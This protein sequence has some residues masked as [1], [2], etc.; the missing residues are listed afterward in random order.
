MEKKFRI[1]LAAFMVF[2]LAFS[3]LFSLPMTVYAQDG[4]L[5]DA[6]LEA[7]N[8]NA[9]MKNTKEGEAGINTESTEDTSENG[10]NITTL[11]NYERLNKTEEKDIVTIADN[12]VATVDGKEYSSLKE[13][14]GSITKS[15]TVTLVSDVEMSESITIPANIA[16]TLTSDENNHTISM[17]STQN[18]KSHSVFVVEQGGTLVIDSEK[19]T[20]TRAKSSEDLSGLILCHGTLELKN[21]ILDGND[22]E[23]NSLLNNKNYSAGIVQVCGESATFTMNGGEIKNAKTLYNAGGVRVCCDAI[24]YLKGGTI[25]NI[26][27]GGQLNTGPVLVYADNGYYDATGNATFEMDGGIIENN[28]GYRGAGVFVTSTEYTYTATMTMRNGIIQNNTCT[29]LGKDA[30]GAGAGIYIQAKAEVSMS[31][32]SIIHNTVNG[33]M[34]G[35]VATADG[36]YD[37]FGSVEE[38]EAAGWTIEDYSKLYPAKFEMT[39]GTISGNKVT[40]GGSDGDG[41][42]GG[43]IYSASNTVTLKGG[44][45][46]RNEAERQGG[47][48]YLGAIPYTLTIYDAL[49]TNNEA[50]I[51]GGGVWACP[52][53]DTEVFVT[54]GVGI[55]D[56]SSKGAGD[57]VASVKMA[58]K[59]YVLTLAG[60]ILGGGQVLWYKDGGIKDNEN[61]LGNPDGSPRY[62]S[63]DTPISQIKNSEDPYALKAIV[64]DDAEKLAQENAK[65]FLRNNKSARGGGIGTNGGIVMG[66]KDNEYTLKVKKDWEDTDESLKQSVTV[67]LKV[68]D[69]V[70]DPVALSRD[71]NWQAEFKDLPNPNTFDNVSYAVAEDPVPDNFTVEY[72]EAVID[73]D[74]RTITIDITNTYHASKKYGGLTVEKEVTGIHGDKDKEFHFTVTLEDTTINGTYGDMKF[75]N[76][77]AEITLKHGK[78]STATRLPAGIGYTIVEKEANADSYTTS[79][80]ADKGVIPE[81][82]NAD[83]KFIN[84]KEVKPKKPDEPKE[85]PKTGNQIN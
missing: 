9:A 16:V 52:T 68:G 15:G 85:N 53:G 6:T 41:G 37:T 12:T 39:G 81:N 59:D 42:C 19:L 77:V 45:I 20:I 10:E 30:A 62:S 22:N 24:F 55:Y 67:Y 44:I 84:H 8:D 74:S 43:G 38:A 48:V 34:G 28:S 54:N 14:I 57:D 26:D 80:T 61:S 56:N 18:T 50:D 69:T 79:A 64:S 70:L 17:I 78:K 51:L 25:S 23:I 7:G 63:N 31:G 46:E 58:E 33:G 29:G 72:K 35:A 83:V 1:L 2:T 3:G 65:L 4:A 75:K 40:T 60:R 47:G 73:N 21:G 11:E 66:E 49:V 71:N 5:A 13:A 32:G 82:D 27:G 36:F 76:G